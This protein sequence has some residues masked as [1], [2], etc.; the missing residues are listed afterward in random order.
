MRALGTLSLGLVLAL[1]AAPAIAGT[2]ADYRPTSGKFK[3]ENGVRVYRALETKPRTY[4]AQSEVRVFKQAFAQGYRDGF[5]DGFDTGKKKVTKT[6]KTRK[7]RRS[8]HNYGRRYSTSGESPG[9]NR[10]RSNVGYGRPAYL[11]FPIRN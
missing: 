8:R 6:R 11:A 5:E 10:F 4:T 1:S 3:L 9:Y 2:M 7:I